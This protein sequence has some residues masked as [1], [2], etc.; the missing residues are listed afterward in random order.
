MNYKNTRYLLTKRPEGMPE[1]DCWAIDEEAIT[2]LQ[3]N[4]ILIKADYLSIDPYMRGRMNDGMSYAAPVQLGEVMVGE[5]VGR[6][7]ESKSNKYK[8]GDL[9]TVHK[10]WQTCI[11]AKDSEVTILRVPES[12]LPSSVFLGT[13]GM[14]GRTAF[15]GL[16]RVGM[17]KSGE[18]LVVSAA[19]GAVGSV[20]GQLG[21]LAGC[22]VVGVAGGPEKSEYVR[23]SLKLDHCIDYKNDNIL[24]KLKEYCPNGIDIYFENVGGEL[25]KNVAQL[26]NKG[27]RVPVCG[28]IS[29]YNSTDIRSE[30]TPFHV[31]GALNPKPKHR[32]FV[33]TEWMNE[34]EK[35]TSVL[36]E[37]VKNGDIKYRETITEG[38]ENAPQALRDVLSGKNFG[39]QIIKI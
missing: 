34:F 36:H 16:N 21:K 3:N 13:L 39:K 25:T 14:P 6:V 37:H 26:L 18:T 24:E 31:L 10:G 1:D 5:S 2:T 22:H 30:E 12:K 29:K 32:F 9:V 23:N 11:K 27:A 33:V 19:S 4:E 28:F 8:I 20:V 38:F 15:F 35:T 7:I 17:P